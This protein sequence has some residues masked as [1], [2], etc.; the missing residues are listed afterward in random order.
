MAPPR[1]RKPRMVSVDIQDN[2][3][4]RALI[5]AMEQDNP[6]ANLL[7]MPGLVKIRT[8]GALT[9]KR[10]TVESILAREWDINEFQLGDRLDVREH[11]RVGRRRDRFELGTLKEL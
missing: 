1:I 10:E 4:N 7:R 6:H 8:E 11:Q 2:E 3:D 5:E 9:V